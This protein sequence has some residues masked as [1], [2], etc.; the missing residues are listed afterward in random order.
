MR[1]IFFILFLL[2]LSNC[3]DTNDEVIQCDECDVSHFLDSVE[4]EQFQVARFHDEIILQSTESQGQDY[5]VCDGDQL[6]AIENT[7]IIEATGEQFAPCTD[8]SEYNYLKLG[9]F[10]IIETCLPS[11]DTLS[12]T[13]ELIGT[14]FFNYIIHENDTIPPPCESNNP[15]INIYTEENKFYLTT[16][17][18]INSCTL[19]VS[20][21]D[22]MI[23]LDESIACTL[24]VAPT[25]AGRQFEAAFVEFIHCPLYPC[26]VEYTIHNNFLRLMNGESNM[27]AWFYA[28]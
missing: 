7:K 12:S 15:F 8:S 28:R 27:S 2:V 25:E 21:E 11:I 19:E 18:G 9:D 4:S 22:K 26:S 20:L 16:F 1:C 6:T 23:S 14:W 24:A 10:N 5:R 17:L 3:G 13:R